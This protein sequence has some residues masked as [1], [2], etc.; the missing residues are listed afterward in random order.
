MIFSWLKSESREV[1]QLNKD[2]SAIVEMAR[3]TYRA[4]RQIEIAQLIADGL[5]QIEETCGSD[6]N[7]R[8]RELDRAKARHREAR[9]QLNQVTLTGYTLLIIHL[10]A[11]VLGERCTPA[12][13]II[14]DFVAQWEHAKPDNDS[15]LP[16]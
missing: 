1:R 11:E 13:Q 12:K 2:A 15:I 9:R 5:Q 7:C 16:G 4:D 8:A 3:Q 10:R 6:E 14:D